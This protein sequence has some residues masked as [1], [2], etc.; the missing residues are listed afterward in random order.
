MEASRVAQTRSAGDDV[1]KRLM[2]VPDAHVTRLFTAQRNGTTVV[3]AV[4]LKQFGNER[5]VPVPDDGV[6]I[7]AL[8]TIESTR[9]ALISF[10]NLPNTGLIGQNLMAHLRSNL[11]IRIP[12]S[13]LPSGLPAALA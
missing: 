3:T 2:V 10:P 7:I 6:V 1:K 4:L 8:G 9:L 12:R 5:T 11:T 13:A